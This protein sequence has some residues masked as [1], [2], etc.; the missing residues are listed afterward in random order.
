MI[1]GL[2]APATNH[3]RG[4]A[5]QLIARNAVLNL[6]KALE[7]RAKT[8]RQCHKRLHAHQHNYQRYLDVKVPRAALAV[9]GW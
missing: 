9:K 7:I 2:L 4:R 6:S 5:P 8:L 3:P 1:V